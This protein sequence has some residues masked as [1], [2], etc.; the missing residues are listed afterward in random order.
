MQEELFTK[1]RLSPLQGVVFKLERKVDL[2]KPCC[3]NFAIVHAGKG[4]HSAELRCK[5]C[6]SHRGW[7]PREAADWFL[8]LLTIFPEAAKDIHVFRDSKPLSALAARRR[9]GGSYTREDIEYDNTEPK[10]GT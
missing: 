9:M 7:L 6:G 1:P 2:Q 5:K 10:A 3:E 4:P 8:T